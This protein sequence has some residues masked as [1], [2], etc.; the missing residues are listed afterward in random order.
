MAYMVIVLGNNEYSLAKVDDSTSLLTLGRKYYLWKEEASGKSTL[1][2]V[3]RPREHLPKA[4][5]GNYWLF[6]VIEHTAFTPGFHLSLVS[7]S[8]CWKAYL[9]A[10]HFPLKTG[11]SCEVTST[12]ERI[13]RPPRRLLKTAALV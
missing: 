8:C 3:K 4:E 12:E 5:K 7:E 13:A 9:L 10:C 11:E 2:R 6:N 1:T